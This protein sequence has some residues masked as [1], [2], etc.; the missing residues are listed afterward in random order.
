MACGQQLVSVINNRIAEENLNRK[1]KVFIFFIISITMASMAV[2]LAFVQEGSNGL[3]NVELVPK[4]YFSLGSN[5]S[6]VKRSGL[7]QRTETMAPAQF[8]FFSKN[9]EK[10]TQAIS[11]AAERME[12]SIQDLKGKLHQKHKRSLLPSD[13]LSTDVLT[14]IANVSGCLPYMLPPKCPNNC[15][16]SKYRHITGACNNREHPRWGASNTALARWLPPIYED[17]LSQPKG[18]NQ[19]FLH[20]GFPLPSVREVTRNIIEVP[21]E[22]VTEDELHSDIII[23][24]G[25]YIDHDLAFTPQSVNRL[26]FLGEVDCQLTCENRNLCFPI[27]IHAND[28]F[29]MSVDCMPFYRSSPACATGHQGVLLGN[30]SVLNPRQ[31][32]NSLTSFLDASTVYGSTTAAE[33]KLRNLTSEEGLLRINM[34]YF[35]NGREYLPFVDQV[36][37]PCAQD[38][39]ADNAERIECFM[40]GDTRSSE[41]ISLAAIHTLWLRQHNHLARAL[42]KLNPHWSSETVYQETRKIVGALH[43]IITIRDYIPK[44][45]GPDAFNQHIGPYK[46]YDP[47]INPTVANVFSTAAFR[48]AH[49]AIHP[50]IKRLNTRYQDDPNLPNLQLHEV[51]FTPWRLVKEGGLDPLLRGTLATPAKLQVQDQLL[52]EELTK[53]LFVLSNNGSLDLASLDLQRGRDHGL[54]GYNDWREFC[55]LPRLRTEGE[56]TTAM[57]NRKVVKK[58]MDLYSNPSNIDVWLGGIVESILPNAT[59]GPLFACII[60][61]Q[62]KALRDGDRFWW[63]NSN[64]FTEAQ[65]HELGK[66]SLSRLICDNTGLTEAPLDAFRLGKFPQD[67]KSCENI[68]SINL[69]AWQET[70]QPELTCSFPDRVDHGDFVHCLETGK[71]MVTYSCQQG[72]K[73]LGE[74]QLTCTKGRWNTK[75]PVCQDINECENKMNPPCHS[76]AKCVNIKGTFE[77]LCTDPYELAEDGKTC[78]DSGRLSKGSLVSIILGVIVVCCLAASGWF[79]ICCWEVVELLVNK[80]M[81]M[82]DKEIAEKL[83]EFFTSVFED[84][85]NGLPPPRTY[86]TQA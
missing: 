26:S 7:L 82:E 51:F 56:L 61:K 27:Q 76:S 22:A 11:Q 34:H 19:G 37:S 52:N 75:P 53:K 72:Y 80:G 55:N 14:V 36:P 39:K 73:L 83:N 68:P 60:G 67:F 2:F 47:T 54:P 21:N 32:I 31:Q 17:G 71:S 20:N 81:L 13:L 46:G 12:A 10:E 25:Q 1:I 5:G 84:E 49:A 63:E 15:M 16:T 77:C 74:E 41:V 43:Q 70:L 79:V 30:L 18:W 4:V 86:A 78:T 23:V 85:D 59:T 65:R 35:D 62:M 45:I 40:A 66:Y 58:I 9:P 33:N 3:F 6:S 42:K 28:S 69:G 24:W 64:V 50:I 8:L 44:I 29:S 38:P 57:E 48:F